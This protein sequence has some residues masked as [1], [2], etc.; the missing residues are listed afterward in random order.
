MNEVV[1]LEQQKVIDATERVKVLHIEKEE[2]LKRLE[3]FL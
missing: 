2:A 3:G 1:Y